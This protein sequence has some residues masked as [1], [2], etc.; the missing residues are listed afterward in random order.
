MQE[1]RECNSNAAQA[2][3]TLRTSGPT[4]RTSGPQRLAYVKRTAALGGSFLYSVTSVTTREG[5]VDYKGHHGTNE[6]LQALAARLLCV[7]A[8]LLQEMPQSAHNSGGLQQQQ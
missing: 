5:Y 1:C 7:T 3:T 2:I 6:A 4:L 8:A